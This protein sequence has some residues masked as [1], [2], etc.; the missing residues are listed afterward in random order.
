MAEGTIQVPQVCLECQQHLLS[1]SGG[2]ENSAADI[3][4]MMTIPGGIGWTK[5]LICSSF[6]CKGHHESAAS[7]F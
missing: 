4:I 3:F 1:V 6:F 5:S 7:W 2:Y